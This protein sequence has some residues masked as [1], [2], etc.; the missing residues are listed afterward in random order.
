MHFEY[1]HFIPEVPFVSNVLSL[2]LL[3]P[4]KFGVRLVRTLSI[5]L[6]FALRYQFVHQIIFFLSGLVGL[7]IICGEPKLE[8]LYVNGIF[9]ACSE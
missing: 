9:R 5:S 2:D 3:L 1:F 6:L 4:R 8:I 7:S